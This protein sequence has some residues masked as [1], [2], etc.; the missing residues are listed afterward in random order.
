MDVTC[1]RAGIGWRWYLW[2]GRPGDPGCLPPLVATGWVL[3]IRNA[4]PAAE[5]ARRRQFRR[6]AAS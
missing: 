1:K 3:L 4:K 5:R 6:E 2:E